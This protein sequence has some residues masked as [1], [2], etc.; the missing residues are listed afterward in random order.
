MKI[1]NIIED[2]T[3]KLHKIS[4]KCFAPKTVLN[5]QGR[6]VFICRLKAFEKFYIWAQLNYD[7][8]DGFAEKSILERIAWWN[9]KTSCK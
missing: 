7:L 2:D 3:I 5:S 8:A 6:Q 4:F 9:M 1:F